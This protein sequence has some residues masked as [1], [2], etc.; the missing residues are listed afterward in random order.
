[1]QDK[2]VEIFA[3]NTET[4]REKWLTYVKENFPAWINVHDPANRS[5]FRDKY[6]IWATP[7]IFL[8]DEQKKIIA[9]KLTVEQTEEIINMELERG[10]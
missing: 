3:V 2:G 7:L 8:L 1:M 6:D 9:K 5:G 4:D 10:N